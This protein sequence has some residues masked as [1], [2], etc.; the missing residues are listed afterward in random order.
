MIHPAKILS[1][2]PTGDLRFELDGRAFHARH[3]IP[4][5][6][7][8]GVI[9]IGEEYPLELSITMDAPVEY[10]TDQR[11]LLEVIGCGGDCDIVRAQGRIMDYF[12]QDVIRLD[13]IG[14]IAVKLH[15][16]QLSTDYRQGSWLVAEGRLEAAMPSPDHDEAGLKGSI[17]E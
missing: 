4:A 16:P 8:E 2:D 17:V 15:S 14:S 9:N 10:L 5:D 7:A 3:A 11:P 6:E 1:F 12:A 13:G